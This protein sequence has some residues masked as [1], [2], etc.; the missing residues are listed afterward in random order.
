M[1]LLRDSLRLTSRAP[2]SMRL[3]RT[4]LGKYAI[5]TV[6]LAQTPQLLPVGHQQWIRPSLIQE[7]S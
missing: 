6:T 1:G 7:A 3:R 4:S 5:S 2:V